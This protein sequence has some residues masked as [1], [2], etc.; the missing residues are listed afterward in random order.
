MQALH[1]FFFFSG[2][3]SLCVQRVL[4]LFLQYSVAGA[5]HSLSGSP[6]LAFVQHQHRHV[7][8]SNEL[9]TNITQ[10]FLPMS[11][12]VALRVRSQLGEALL[13][14][15]QLSPWQAATIRR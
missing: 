7:R 4:P 10:R 14:A 9:A 15:A 1:L 6:A 5:L 3:G 2:L 12:R 8:L 11:A 13:L